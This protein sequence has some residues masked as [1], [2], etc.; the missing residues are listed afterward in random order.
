MTEPAGPAESDIHALISWL[1]AEIKKVEDIARGTGPIQWRAVGHRVAGKEGDVVG[2]F[3]NEGNARHAAWHDPMTVVIRCVKDRLIVA[4]CVDVIGDR[5][6][7][8]YGAPGLLDGDPEAAAVTLAAET[9]ID[10]ASGYARGS[11][12][13]GF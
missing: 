11:G 12:P 2:S 1:R 3:E 9:L 5:D 6:L 8:N 4:R 7:S 10:L 13:T